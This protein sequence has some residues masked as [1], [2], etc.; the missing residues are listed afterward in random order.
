MPPAGWSRMLSFLARRRAALPLRAA[1]SLRY[2]TLWHLGILAEEEFLHLLAQ[3]LAGIGVGQIQ[4]I[5]VDEQARMLLPH[6]PG[7][8]RDIVI[9]ALAN[10]TGDG[11]FLQPWQLP[12]QFDTM[13]H[14]RHVAISCPVI[15]GV[16]NFHVCRTK[17]ILYR[18]EAWRDH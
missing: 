7:L 11:R 13:Y 8:L 14:P 2:P 16:R 17:R 5:M 9:D 6:L 15:L 3:D 18:S 10:L 4:P 1:R 12:A